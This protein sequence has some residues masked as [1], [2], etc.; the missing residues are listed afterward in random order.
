MTSQTEENIFTAKKR[1]FNDAIKN[2]AKVL[3]GDEEQIEQL[4][5][6]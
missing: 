3:G 6:A 1:T 2:P 4:L 5:I